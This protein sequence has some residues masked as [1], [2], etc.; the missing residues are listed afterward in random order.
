MLE[1]LFCDIRISDDLTIHMLAPNFQSFFCQNLRWRIIQKFNLGGF[2]RT[3]AANQI[4]GGEFAC[5][6]EMEVLG[7][8]LLFLIDA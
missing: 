4:S 2:L 1:F 3:L 6:L 7:Y 8:L 5:T